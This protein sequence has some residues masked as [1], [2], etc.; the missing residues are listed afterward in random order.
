MQMIV[1]TAGRSKAKL[2]AEEKERQN[3]KI[4]FENVLAQNQSGNLRSVQKKC[5]QE[6]ILK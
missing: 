2:S 3:K 6:Q 1:S 4:S 5:T